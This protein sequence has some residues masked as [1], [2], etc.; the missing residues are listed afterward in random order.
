MSLTTDK[1]TE[2]PSAR[3]HK[4]KYRT[5]TFS[6]NFEKIKLM[7]LNNLIIHVYILFSNT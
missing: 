6:P 4:Y 1:K 5:S 3:S 2:M 7:K